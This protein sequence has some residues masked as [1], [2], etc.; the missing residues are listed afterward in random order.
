[1]AAMIKDTL[2]DLVRTHLGP[3][4]QTRKGWY[5]RNCMM[6]HHHGE[7]T[8]RRKRFGIIF[9]PNGGI[10]TSCFNC[11]HKSKF[12]P[13]E[14]FSKEFSLFLQEIGIPH[15][16]VKLLN[17]DLY[18]AHYGKDA[19]Y[20]LQIAENIS[21]KW[22]AATLPSKALTIQDWADAGC[23]DKSF[24]NVLRYAYGRGIRN[25]EQFYWTP[26]TNGMLNKRLIVPFTYR[27]NIVG[28]TGRFAGTP[29][30]KNITKY[31]NISPSDFI[32]NLDRQKPHNDYIILCE[33]VLDAY[34]TNGI[35]TQGNEINESQVAFIQSLN[36]TVI[37]LPDFDKDGRALVNLA[38]KNNWAISFPFWSHEVKDAASAVEKY[39]RV[40]TVLSILEAA[41]YSAFSAQVKWRMKY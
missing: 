23:T 25:F 36:K 10:A 22:V 32:Y 28:F 24:L 9:S 33:G 1:M 13:G 41:D 6:C 18:K 35:S 39:G 14:T 8:D 30:D 16:T 29:P 34:Y 37:V 27:N 15:N 19:V 20:D 3:V 40:V 21:A 7:S 2:E 38:V 11:S 31:Y 26:Q 17:F 12:V 4:Q 5:S